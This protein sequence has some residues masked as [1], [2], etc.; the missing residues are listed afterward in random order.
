MLTTG[1]SAIAL[2]G[3]KFLKFYE[4]WVLSHNNYFVPHILV[5]IPENK[6]V[7]QLV[8]HFYY[9]DTAADGSELYCYNTG[10]DRN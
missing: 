5:M 3:L 4:S 10:G 1:T 8:W 9:V 6:N 2:S 7:C